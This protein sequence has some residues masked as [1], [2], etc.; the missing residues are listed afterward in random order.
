MRLPSLRAPRGGSSA[1]TPGLTLNADLHHHRTECCA[2]VRPFQVV[3]P[4]MT[5][6]TDRM[7]MYSASSTVTGYSG[8]M[9]REIR[10]ADSRCPTRRRPAATPI[11]AIPV[12]SA[13]TGA[14]NRTA[15]SRPAGSKKT[16]PS[17]TQTPMNGSNRLSNAANRFFENPR[18]PAPRSDT[19]GSVRHPWRPPGASGTPPP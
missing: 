10:S 3:R 16:I 2:S 18:R 19:S 5:R 4:R 1:T 13:G 7:A 15:S 12:S 8:I 17:Q 6:T 14:P 9:L 11:S